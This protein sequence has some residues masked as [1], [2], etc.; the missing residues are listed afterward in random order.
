[1]ATALTVFRFGCAEAN[2]YRVIL[3]FV[4]DIELNE[5]HRVHWLGSCVERGAEGR[6]TIANRELRR[7]R[8]RYRPAAAWTE[9]G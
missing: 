8:R 1:M 9:R 2:G 7:T 5:F 6:E 4:D 3:R